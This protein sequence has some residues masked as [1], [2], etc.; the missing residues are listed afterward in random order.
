M[1]DFY[2]RNASEMNE[3]SPRAIARHIAITGLAALDAFLRRG[4]ASANRNRVQFLYLH[5]VFGD[6]VGAFR[7]LLRDLA[8]DYTFLPYGEA[9][10]RIA[11]G[12]VDGR[13][14]ALSFDDGFAC[15]VQAGTIM[16]EAGISACFFLT[17]GIIGATD[18]RAI[19]EFCRVRLKF[20]SV[21]FMGWRDVE[22]LLRDGHEIGG[23][24]R[25]H[26]NLATIPPEM[27]EA[28]VGG[29]YEDLQQRIG[30]VEH[31]A[32]P[33]GQF[34]DFS[35]FA[36][37][38][39]YSSGFKSCA[40]AVRGCHVASGAVPSNGVC[41]RRDHIAVTWPKT[42]VRYF[43]ERNSRRATASNNSWP[44][45][46]DPRRLSPEEKSRLE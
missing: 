31:F 23:H 40:S 5:H 3:S 29:C 12:N 32:W 35:P 24:T 19:E 41:L 25:T 44:P 28:E 15:N 10:A 20:F 30:N 26:P 14:V 22:Q 45:E 8:N 2:I 33:F 38:T 17:T 42:H 7:Q 1:T 27:V 39:V 36:A 9:V 6:E 16:K 46:L 43:L 13:Y 18:P 21:E 34:S 11:S 4:T 37:K